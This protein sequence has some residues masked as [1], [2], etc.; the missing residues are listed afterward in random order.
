MVYQN[1]YLEVFSFIKQILFLC[2]KRFSGFLCR[3]IS[4][5]FPKYY[6]VFQYISLMRQKH[7][8]PGVFVP[9]SM[10]EGKQSLLSYCH[11]YIHQYYTCLFGSI[12]KL[13]YFHI[14]FPRIKFIF[15]R[16]MYFIFCYKFNFLHINKIC[17]FSRVKNWP[18]TRLLTTSP[19]ILL[20]ASVLTLIQYPFPNFS[21]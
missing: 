21:K 7:R 16:S 4:W 20:V 15:W 2:A 12:T 19:V 1:Y 8:N 3:Y 17:G 5:C 13:S 6:P 14:S 9:L 10:S 11:P 18:R